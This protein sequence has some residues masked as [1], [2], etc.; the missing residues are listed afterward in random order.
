M[1]RQTCNQ[2][3]H[4][5]Y[6]TIHNHVNTGHDNAPVPAELLHQVQVPNRDTCMHDS[7]LGNE[8]AVPRAT[9][10]LQQCKYCQNEAAVL[11]KCKLYPFDDWNVC[12]TNQSCSLQIYL[13][14]H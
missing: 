11:P 12:K 3:A 8:G 14:R 10:L 6:A 7:A 5:V 4:T 2:I 9:S 13:L 1:P